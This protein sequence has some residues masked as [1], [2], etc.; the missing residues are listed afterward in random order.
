MRLRAPTKFDVFGAGTVFQGAY[1]ANI[2]TPTDVDWYH[3]TDIGN[4]ALTYPCCQISS[5]AP[6]DITLHGPDGASR[7]FP[8]V[9]YVDL[10][11]PKPECWIEVRCSK[12]TQYSIFFGYMLDKNQLPTPNQLP[13]IETIP[14]WWPDPP[15]VL[16]E[17]E[18]WLEIT[19]NEELRRHGRLELKGDRGLT[20]D[21]LTQD[22]SVLKSGAAQEEG[23]WMLDV[24]DLAPGKYLLRVGRDVRAAARF[25]GV[26]R[27][28]MTFRVGPGF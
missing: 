28:K 14:D 9:K 4:R 18:K 16:R 17:W 8:P 23:R 3:V 26:Q 1:D 25:E 15:F 10:R 11:L 22:R 13:N 5:D 12:A 24:R 21:L 27:K 2:Q 6:L 20:W 19:V 7:P